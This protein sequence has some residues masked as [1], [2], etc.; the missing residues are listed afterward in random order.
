MPSPLSHERPNLTALLSRKGRVRGTP[1]RTASAP[2]QITRRPDMPPPLIP[3]PL[4]KNR[5]RSK[6]R[7]RND[8]SSVAGESETQNNSLRPAADRDA[9]RRDCLCNPRAQRRAFADH[10]WMGRFVCLKDRQL[11]TGENHDPSESRQIILVALL[12]RDNS[13]CGPSTRRKQRSRHNA[14]DPFAAVIQRGAG[15][16]RR[17]YRDCLAWTAGDPIR[18][19]TTIPQRDFGSVHANQKHPSQRK[20]DPTAPHAPNC[21]SLLEKGQAL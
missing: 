20:R 5:V 11:A 15:T 13:R 4:G 2:F 12:G 21:C 3:N 16:C 1:S 8:R 7:C 17:R 9:I 6:N 14:S 19:W 18:G 10:D